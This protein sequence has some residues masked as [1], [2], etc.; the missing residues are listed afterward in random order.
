MCLMISLDAKL[1]E[2]AFRFQLGT[3][4]TA[5]NYTQYIDTPFINNMLLRFMYTPNTYTVL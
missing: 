4:S 1:R 5:I 2:G 3:G